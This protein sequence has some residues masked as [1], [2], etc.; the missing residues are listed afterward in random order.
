VCRGEAGPDGLLQ[1]HVVIHL[2][3]PTST[4]VPVL[5]AFMEVAMETS[6]AA[7]VQSVLRMALCSMMRDA[8]DYLQTV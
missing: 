4:Y 8:H 5:H 7:C 2:L 6:V 3:V 1:G